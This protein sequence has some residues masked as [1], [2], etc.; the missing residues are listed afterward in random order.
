M[1]ASFLN[2]KSKQVL[3]YVLEVPA[4]LANT[5]IWDDIAAV[6]K[7]WVRV[8]LWVAM[9]N[10]GALVAKLVNVSDEH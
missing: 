9:A 6:P 5:M 8:E 10:V 7:H 1:L 2:L 3:F 4:K